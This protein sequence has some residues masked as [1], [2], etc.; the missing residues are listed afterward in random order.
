MAEEDLKKAFVL[1]EERKGKEGRLYCL[2]SLYLAGMLK[3]LA[4]QE[5]L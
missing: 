2:G 4:E 5:E 3:S 1:A